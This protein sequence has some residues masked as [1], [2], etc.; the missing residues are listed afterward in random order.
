MLFTW[1]R[2]LAGA[3]GPEEPRG[4]QDTLILSS[5][6]NDHIGYCHLESESHFYS[7]DA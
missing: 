5:H 2:D 6:L 1:I 3:R 7:K 4:P